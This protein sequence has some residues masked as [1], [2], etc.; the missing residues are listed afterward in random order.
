MAIASVGNLGTGASST[1]NSTLGFTTSAQLDAGNYGI[2]VI[3]SDNTST[4][5]GD[6]SEVTGVTV[7]GNAMT[8]IAEY[9]NG[10]AGAG[11]GVLVSVWKYKA[12]IS[13]IINY[14]KIQN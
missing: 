13:L 11:A 6:N 7:G 2:L 3:S 1:S 9:V 5:D 14:G 12:V 8:K 10:S 4:T